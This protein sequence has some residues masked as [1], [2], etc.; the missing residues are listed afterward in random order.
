MDPFIGAALISGAAQLGGGVMS[1]FGAS[2]A[3]AANQA[4]NAQ[5]LQFQS[6]WNQNARNYQV[7]QNEL[8][9]AAMKDQQQFSSYW[10]DRQEK[11]QERMSSTAYARAMLDMKQAG[12]NPILAY[13]QGGAQGAA[14]AS[15]SPG[16]WS[17]AAPTVGSAPENKFGMEN[18][19]AELGRAVG[20]VASSA[21]DTY[22]AG[23]QSKL[24]GSQR[25]LT[26]EGTRKVG[27]ET[28]LLDASEGKVLA[29]T[30]TEKQRSELVKAQKAAAIASSAQSY[31]A[32]GRALEE[33]RQFQKHGM[34]GYGLGERII[35]GLEVPPDAGL[36]LPEPSF[37]FNR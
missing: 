10:A 27:Y 36:K 22:K 1:A 37:P 3:N 6:Q 31:A 34:P 18:T 28:K 7:E 15:A 32:A 33:T 13:Q 2:Q 26:D 16:Q 24:I 20:R 5:N 17:G 35:R 8:N 23:E 11:F 25:A 21:V 19:Q 14:G 12:L 29:E 30:D 9:W 4:L